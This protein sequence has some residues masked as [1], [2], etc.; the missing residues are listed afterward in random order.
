MNQDKKLTLCPYCG[1]TQS[2][3][4]HCQACGGRFDVLNRKAMQL[5]MGPWFVR[6]PAHPF[7]PGCSY[8]VLCR[9]IKLG[10]VKAS[11]IIRGPST[12]QFWTLA[13]NVPG[14]AHLLGYCHRCGCRCNP[15]RQA[16]PDCSEPFRPVE[17][18]NELGLMYRSPAAVTAARHNL[19]RELV[20]QSNPPSQPPPDPLTKLTPKRPFKIELEPAPSV[21]PPSPAG[22]SVALEVDPDF[23]SSL[24]DP[25]APDLLPPSLPANTSRIVTAPPPPSAQ[26]IATTVARDSM[27]RES[28]TPSAPQSSAVALAAPPTTPARAKQAPAEEQILSIKQLNANSNRM[29][30]M[31]WLLLAINMVTLGLWIP[32]LL[33]SDSTADSPPSDPERTSDPIVRN[34]A[35]T[36]ASAAVSNPQR[37]PLPPVEKFLPPISDLPQ[38]G[39]ISTAAPPQIPTTL[40]TS[41]VAAQLAQANTFIQEGKS[42]EALA[43]LESI[44]QSTPAE[45]RP[46]GLD[47]Y[48]KQ[49]EE[50]VA[51]AEAASFFGIPVD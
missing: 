3:T 39:P 11:T 37:Q 45:D 10:N 4:D 8:E 2:S 43:L 29:S 27:T 30:L 48:I 25:L 28:V 50:R 14:I 19:E 18:R 15:S 13:R 49:L 42:K 32:S 46:V 6:D 21:T 33:D 31:L 23:D 22:D 16:C 9:Q 40:M 38:P 26:P 5:K 12:H 1:N 7:R 34:A 51:H 41:P 20:N 44:A 35:G 36:G 24:D 47:Q 17:D